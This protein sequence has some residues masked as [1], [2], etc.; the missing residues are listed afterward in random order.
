MRIKSLFTLFLVAVVCILIAYFTLFEPKP[1]LDPSTGFETGN[2]ITIFDTLKESYE[3]YSELN[4]VD[5]DAQED[6]Y[7]Q[8][9]SKLNFVNDEIKVLK[10]QLKNIESEHAQKED[11]LRKDKTDELNKKAN[12]LRAKITDLENKIDTEK[13]NAPEQEKHL[14][15]SSD[16]I[17]EFDARNGNL[18]YSFGNDAIT[19]FNEKL[20]IVYYYQFPTYLVD[21][22][23]AETSAALVGTV[24]F[25]T[26]ET[27]ST[28]VPFF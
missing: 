13:G 10:A 6:E 26:P 7:K 21:A 3:K 11:Q 18:Y 27:G 23:R 2:T 20:E 14:V 22:G 15:S 12:E 5:Y 17:P 16:L 9:G 19:V 25:T 28:F 24:I 1:E 8:L 4:E